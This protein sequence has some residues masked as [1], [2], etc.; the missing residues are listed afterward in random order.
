MALLPKGWS[1]SRHVLPI[2]A[3]V[4]LLVAIYV[5]IA[6]Q[7]DRTL[8]DPAEKPAH[9]VGSLAGAPRVA[10]SG[11]VEPSSELVSIG[12]SLPGL[13]TDV[14]VRPGDYVTKGQPLFTVDERAQRAR[15]E[16]SRAAIAQAEAA[17]AEATSASETAGR[18]LALYRQVEDAACLP[19]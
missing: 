14:L 15:L 19:F 2:V 10:G 8:D 4:G 9:A 7:P 18:Q 13:V 6:G 12:T 16:E 5:M 1:I 17:I 11:V 3:F